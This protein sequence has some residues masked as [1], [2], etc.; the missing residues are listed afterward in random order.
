MQFYLCI[1]ACLSLL[2]Q[3]IYGMSI[4][5]ALL[6]TGV[7]VSTTSSLSGYICYPY[8]QDYKEYAQKYKT[9]L[10]MQDVVQEKKL[11]LIKAATLSATAITTSGLLAS[12]I[13]FRR[14]PPF[15]VSRAQNI[16]SMRNIQ[17]LNLVQSTQHSKLIPQICQHYHDHPLPRVQALADILKLIKDSQQAH[18]LLLRAQTVRH[19][20]LQMR[21]TVAL[22][23]QE[24]NTDYFKTLSDAFS[25]IKQDKNTL[26]ELKFYP[27][28]NFLNQITDVFW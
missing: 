28:K 5:R 25:L 1:S 10:Y 26:R 11:E 27:D 22:L 8:Y 15:L 4:T 20:S 2:S 7:I 19:S 13:L 23:M 17:L 16:L 14:T 21:D 3:E 12:I 24:V 6:N 18:K 9:K